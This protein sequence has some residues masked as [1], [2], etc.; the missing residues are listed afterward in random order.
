MLF[1]HGNVMVG[2]CEQDCV[3]GLNGASCTRCGSPFV[4]SKLLYPIEEKNYNSDPMISAS[5]KQ[6]RSDLKNAFMVTIFGYSAPTSDMG[7]V[8][9]LSQAWGNWQDRQF[10]QFEIID[11]KPEEQLRQKWKRFIHTHHYE[12]HNDFYKSWIANHPRRTGEAYINQY[13]NA[14]FIEDNPVPKDA[15]F[16]ALWKWMQ[17][18]LQVEDQKRTKNGA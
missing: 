3:T 9:L 4:P 13:L 17:Q 16:D 6:L 1:L 7:A 15:G 12:V 14:L 2:F 8:E 18:L 5:W 11:I 10:E